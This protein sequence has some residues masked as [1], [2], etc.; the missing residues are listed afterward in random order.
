MPV[1]NDWESAML[2]L[3]QIAA[4]AK[5]LQHRF[6][7]MF[8]D[9]GS[10]DLMPPPLPEVPDGLA[11]V[12]TL[13]LRRNLG[14][15]RAIAIAITYL[16]AHAEHDA[17]VV[18]DG[19]GEDDPADIPRL[20]AR[21][22]E[23]GRQ[24]VVFAQRAKRSEGLAFRIGYL[25][26]KTVHSLLV[27]RGVEVGNFSVLPRS[28]LA[29]LVAAWELWNH[30]AAAVYHARLPVDMVPTA[31]AHRIRGESKMNI[32]S[33]VT[34][35][36]SAISVYHDT[37]SVRTLAFL[38]LAALAVLTGL[39]SIVI[40]RFATDLA[41][42]GWATSTAGILLVTMM[43]LA[44]MSMF[45]VLFALRGRSEYAFLPLRDYKLFVLEV[46]PLVQAQ[47]EG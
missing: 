39:T 35:G 12:E 30:Y 11:R 42:P 18:M 41:I 27:G 7:V 46:C 3:E 2:L 14:H 19:D 43:N 17:I 26:F 9:D 31:R 45:M 4:V 47:G 37:V 44:L 8:V 25:G 16:Y 20:L 40:V 13:R 28:A 6:E 33:L 21:F 24:A 22:M 38:S 10:T 15:Q 29:R 36:L 1:Y 5:P 34:H 23:T 32:V